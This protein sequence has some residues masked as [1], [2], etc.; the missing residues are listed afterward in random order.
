[1]HKR[2]LIIQAG[3]AKESCQQKRLS[4]KTKGIELV[5]R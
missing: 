3:V 5:T 4:G 2:E 1:M